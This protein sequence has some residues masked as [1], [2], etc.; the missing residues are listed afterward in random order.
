MTGSAPADTTHKIEESSFV[1]R[2]KEA[3]RL[4]FP[5]AASRYVPVEHD[6]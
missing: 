5:D 1:L 4:L 3:K 6:T 2:K